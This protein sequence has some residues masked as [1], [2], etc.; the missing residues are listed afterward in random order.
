MPTYPVDLDV[1]YGSL[2]LANGKP[3]SPAT[4][5]TYINSINSIYRLLT[6]E[7]Y[8]DTIDMLT[9]S[10][11]VIAAINGSNY[12]NKSMLYT[13]IIKL[14]NGLASSS[15]KYAFLKPIVDK[16]YYPQFMLSKDSENAKINKNMADA[17]E[18]GRYLD[19]PTIKDRVEKYPVAHTSGRIMP[20]NL[21]NKTIV[22]FYFCN[23]KNWV[24]RNDLGSLLLAKKADSALL[25]NTQNYLLLTAGNKPDSV[26]LNVYKTSGKYG[27]QM[28]K[29][30]PELK[31]IL[32]QYM[33]YENKRPG[34]YLFANASG[35]A[36]TDAAMLK[37]VYAALQ[38]VLD[39][40]M[41]IDIVRQ[42]QITDFMKTLH[43]SAER[44]ANARAFLHN[45]E[46]AASYVK[47]NINKKIKKTEITD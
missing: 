32:R 33:T 5:K 46:T 15:A 10:A 38:D 30:S 39:V 9:Q 17:D 19:L 25:P 27:T 1:A 45:T 3:L 23:S 26:L 14:F 28:L 43:S 12:R 8:D 4:I 36:Y 20:D 41:T 44:A 7:G 18:L 47:L 22:C 37:H 6:D 29:L 24:P 2:R 11:D 13:A 21:R 31:A 40:N 34:D 16:D 35:Q 42:I